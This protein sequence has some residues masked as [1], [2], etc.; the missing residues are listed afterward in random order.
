MNEILTNNKAGYTAIQSRTVGQEQQC[1]NRSEFKNVTD[2]RTDLPTN[3]PT[4]TA[5]CRVACPPLKI[6]IEMRDEKKKK[7]TDKKKTI[8]YFITSTTKFYILHMEDFSF[9]KRRWRLFGRRRQ[10]REIGSFSN[11]CC[12]LQKTKFMMNIFCKD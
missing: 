11:V 1:E 9:N 6:Q 7:Y 4:D 8:F 3:L 5:R 10:S 2:R 12:L